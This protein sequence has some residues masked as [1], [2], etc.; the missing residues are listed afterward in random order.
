MKAVFCQEC[1]GHVGYTWGEP[2]T[3]TLCFFCARPVAELMNYFGCP[4]A[5]HLSYSNVQTD[6]EREAMENE[7]LFYKAFYNYKYFTE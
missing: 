4:D 5:P 6:K 3:D 7:H 2:S 1:G